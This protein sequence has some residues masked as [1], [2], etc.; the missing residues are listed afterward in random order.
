MEA[1]LKLLKT[2]GFEAATT[3]ETLAL[4]YEKPLKW[5]LIAREALVLKVSTKVENTEISDVEA[6]MGF[7]TFQKY[8]EVFGVDLT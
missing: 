4:P 8:S 5:L 7:P 3:A 1:A 2:V 6:K